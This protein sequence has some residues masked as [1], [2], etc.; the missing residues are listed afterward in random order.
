MTEKQKSACSNAV[1]ITVSAVVGAVLTA[2]S[3][4]ATIGGDRN[5]FLDTSHK[6]PVIEARVSRIELQIAEDR[7]VARHMLELLNEVRNDVRAIRSKT[8]TARP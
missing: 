5:L 4:G 6:M 1:K 8:E 3:V 7:I 2:F